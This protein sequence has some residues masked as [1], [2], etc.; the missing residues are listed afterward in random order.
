MDIGAI[1]TTQP[2]HSYV[3]GMYCSFPSPH[4]GCVSRFII[5]EPY[6]HALSP[7][8][9]RV[10]NSA[11]LLCPYLPVAICEPTM[12]N[13]GSILGFPILICSPS[14]LYSLLLCCVWIPTTLGCF[15]DLGH[16][17][18]LL[19]YSRHVPIHHTGHMYTVSQLY[20]DSPRVPG[21]SRYMYAQTTSMQP[22]PPPCRRCTYY[23]LVCCCGS[24]GGVQTWGVVDEGQTSRQQ[25]TS[26]SQLA[27]AAKSLLVAEAL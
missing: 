27:R 25:N 8:A 17:R 1:D 10:L 26:G 4:G 21:R 6:R 11:R 24:P 20:P 12:Y 13:S 9:E 18:V 22:P 14:L 2:L 19:W 23:L 5:P 7:G 16:L 3:V 15:Y